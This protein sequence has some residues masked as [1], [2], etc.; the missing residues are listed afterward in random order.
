MARRHGAKEIKPRLQPRGVNKKDASM[1]KW[2]KLSDIP[3]DEEDKC[4]SPY[5][6]LV[7]INWNCTI[8]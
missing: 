2:N 5:I 3:M 7:Q 8:F 6:P 4:V 1:K